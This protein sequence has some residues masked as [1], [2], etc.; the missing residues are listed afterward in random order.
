MSDADD[1]LRQAIAD[2]DLVVSADW[3]REYL[4]NADGHRRLVI[5]AAKARTGQGVAFLDLVQTG[6]VGLQFAVRHYDPTMGYPFDGFGRRWID[7]A[8]SL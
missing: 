1:E 4:N 8:L 2:A 5:E 3:V 7:R 6:E